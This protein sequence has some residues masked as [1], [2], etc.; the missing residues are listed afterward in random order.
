MNTYNKQQQYRP[1]YKRKEVKVYLLGEYIL[2]LT[3][4]NHKS[5]YYKEVESGDCTTYNLSFDMMIG[6]GYGCGV[7]KDSGKGFLDV[8]GSV[9]DWK[10]FYS[11]VNREF[12]A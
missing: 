11:L 9:D 5:V 4:A 8:V 2:R 1:H 12:E 3:E 10:R 7:W 6:I